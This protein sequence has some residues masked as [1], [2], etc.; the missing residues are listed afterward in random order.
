MWAAG[1]AYVYVCYGIHQML[2]IVTNR[3]EGAAVLIRAGKPGR[4][5]VIGAP[6]RSRDP[7]R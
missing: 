3:V 5:R 6:R 4:A 2:N 1:H 7:S